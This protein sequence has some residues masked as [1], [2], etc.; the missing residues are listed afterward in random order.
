[1]Y[2]KIILAVLHPFIHIHVLS[3]EFIVS[4]LSSFYHPLRTGNFSKIKAKF[5]G[6]LDDSSFRS[7]SS[8]TH[9]HKSAIY[10]AVSRGIYSLLKDIRRE[11]RERAFPWPRAISFFFI[12][13]TWWAVGIFMAELFRMSDY[14]TLRVE[15]VFRYMIGVI[16]SHIFPSFNKN[17][18]AYNPSFRFSR[19]RVTN[20]ITIYRTRRLPVYVSSL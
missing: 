10:I 8:A 9:T 7:V 20:Q 4:A 6:S 13:R 5:R 14:V 3:V 11:K 1:M 12:V 2:I 19:Y 16:R 17:F 18:S 15:H